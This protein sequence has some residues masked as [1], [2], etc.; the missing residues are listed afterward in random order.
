MKNDPDGEGIGNNPSDIVICSDRTVYIA[1]AG[2]NCVLAQTYPG[3]T[4]VVEVLVTDEETIY[5]IEFASG[6]DPVEGLPPY[7]GRVV[8]VIAEGPTTIAE[9]LNFLCG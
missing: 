9:R 5:A 4:T 6:F 1:D 8:E 3:L 7:S 2:C